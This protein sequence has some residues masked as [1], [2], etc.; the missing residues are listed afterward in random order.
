[1]FLCHGA[2][3]RHNHSV[4]MV[5]F[6]FLKMF[7]S[8]FHS[9]V[10]A[11]SFH[12]KKKSISLQK[13]CRFELIFKYSEKLRCLFLFEKGAALNWVYEFE[14]KSLDKKFTTNLFPTTILIQNQDSP[15]RK[16]AGFF[17]RQWYSTLFQCF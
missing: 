9:Q 14:A 11:C 3:Q 8:I 16:S 4:M 6:F 5:Q 1:M 7:P 10:C 12:R 15:T 13:N 2:P 17:H